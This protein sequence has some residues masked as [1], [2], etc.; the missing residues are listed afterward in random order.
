[1]T[2]SD[3]GL[4][5]TSKREAY[6]L[7]VQQQRAYSVSFFCL[8]LLMV[9]LTLLLTSCAG[10]AERVVTRTDGTSSTTRVAVIA[11]TDAD[12]FSP[13]GWKITGVK[14]AATAE[15]ITKGVVTR[16]VIGALAPAASNLTGSVG[17]ALENV[18]R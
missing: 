10:M 9:I 3:F 6:V 8:A 1:M 18:S 2:P 4:P 11:G 13:P 12:E 14:Q 7:H 16:A 5:D 15:K 17:A